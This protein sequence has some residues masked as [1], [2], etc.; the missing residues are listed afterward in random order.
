MIRI[1]LFDYFKGIYTGRALKFQI[2]RCISLSKT[3]RDALM[4]SA[5]KKRKDE[6][7]TCKLYFVTVVGVRQSILFFSLDYITSGEW[8][9]KTLRFGAR[10]CS[11]TNWIEI[12]I[13][14]VRDSEIK[15]HAVFYRSHI[16]FGPWVKNRWTIHVLRTLQKHVKNQEPIRAL[17]IKYGLWNAGQKSRFS[18]AP[19]RS[20]IASK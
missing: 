12:S 5:K 3:V 4:C 14:I 11:F 18:S 13:E 7:P 19:S 1:K 17:P 9:E 6:G 16:V 10:W 20:H 2:P 15:T 8:L